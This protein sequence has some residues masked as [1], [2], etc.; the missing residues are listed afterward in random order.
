[1]IRGEAG[2]LPQERNRSARKWFKSARSSTVGQS[3][4]VRTNVPT[5]ERRSFA[6]TQADG[7][8]TR[9]NEH[10]DVIVR[11]ADRNNSDFIPVGV[12]SKEYAL[13][14]HHEVMDVVLK[15]LEASDISADDVDANLEITEYRRADRLQPAFPKAL[16]LRP[17]RRP[18]HGASIGM[19]ELGRWQHRVSER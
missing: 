5:F 15:A 19:P 17:G 3:S 11:A 1:M 18:S 14:Q 4:R 16:C 6:L 7:N 9:L 13:I 2:A 12:V 10:Q 8:R